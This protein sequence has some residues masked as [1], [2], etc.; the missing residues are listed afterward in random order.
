MGKPG[1]K[2]PI[3]AAAVS[4]F[5]LTCMILCGAENLNAQSAPRQIAVPL[6]PMGWSSWN[7]FSNT[8]DSD[9]VAAQARAMISTGMHK[10]GYQYIN[11]DE[12]WWLGKRDELGNIVVDA[13][14][15]PALKPGER[16][17][18]MSNIV[19]YIHGLGLKA[20]IYTDAGLNGC[21]TVGPDLGPG[22]PFEGSEGHYEQDFLQFARW[23]FDYVKVDWCGGNKENLDPAVQYAE[24]ARAIARAEAITGHRLYYSIC[25]WGNNSPW[26]WAPNIGG[27]E[28]D[29]W[30]TSGDIVAPIVAH[31]I[32][33]GRKASFPGVL[34]NFDKGIHPEAEHTGFYNDPDMMVLGMPGLTDAENRVH[35][36]LWAISGAP[37]LVGAD[38]TTLS[39]ATR[40]TLTNSAVIAVDQDALGIQ[41]V[42]V[43]EPAAGLDVWSRMLSKAGQRAVL[44]LNRSGNAATIQVN[45]R[46]LGL[47]DSSA[48]AT[49][50]WTGKEL[51][52]FPSSYSAVVPA[53]DALLLAVRGSE[54]KRTHYTAAGAGGKSI[55]RVGVPVIRDRPVSFNHVASRARMAQIQI[56]YSNPDKAPRFAELRV[57]GQV[58]TGIAFPS[59][60][61][62]TGMI[63]IQA[64]LDRTGA[65]NVLSFSTRG[66]PGPSLESISLQ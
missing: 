57:N 22:Y 17:A 20:G 18:D 56:V 40:A 45:W 35:M 12:G 39:D 42:K 3:L 34:K 2:T 53:G 38:L 65:R 6:P 23:G 19:R 50:L 11:I 51:G 49:D 25:D 10:V 47:A 66:D 28:A 63:W 48:T 60:G 32:N 9:V 37:L 52:A 31:S 43:A 55:E 21:G 46:D 61:S 7:S 29:I 54:G 13:K 30:R 59:T 15:W 26:T 58:A 36:G 44:L 8:V 27:V 4:A 5:A 16:A 14:A 64:L 1:Y 62:G 41:A 24:I 33:S